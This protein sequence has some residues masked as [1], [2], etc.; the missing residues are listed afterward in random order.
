MLR[1]DFEATKASQV[2]LLSGGG[3]GHEP[4]H[5]GWLG[6]GMLTAA[7]CGGVFASPSVDAVLSG[8]RACAGP[9][10]VLVIVKN[11]TGDR[12]NFGLACEQA[13]AEG[14]RCEMVIVGDD[15]AV[16]ER[17]ED[18]IAGRRG[19]AGTVFVHKCAGA[20]AAAGAPLAQVLAV[21]TAAERSVGSVG[22]ALDVCSL[23]GQPKNDRLTGSEMEMGLGIHGEPGTQK[24]TALPCDEIVD[25]MLSMIC[26]P[27][28][29][30]RWEGGLSKGDSVVLLVN[31]LGSTPVMEQYV[32]ARRAIEHLETDLGVSV[33]RS[34]VGSFMTSLDMAGVSLTLMKLSYF[35]DLCKDA[36]KARPSSS[37]AP[38]WS[39]VFDPLMLLDAPTGA[40]AWPASFAMQRLPAPEHPVPAASGGVL[41]TAG[42]SGPSISPESAEAVKKA[43]MAAVEAVCAAEE[44]LTAWDAAAGDGDCGTTM[45]RGAEQVTADLPGYDFTSPSTLLAQLAD[46]IGTMGGTSGVI[47]DIFFRACGNSYAGAETAADASSLLD[48]IEAGTKAITFYGGATEGMRTLLDAMVPAHRAGVAAA[49]VE[50]SVALAAMAEAA[51]AG[52]DATRTMA[53]VAGR[54]AYVPDQQ[55]QGTPDPG[56]MAVAFALQAAATAASK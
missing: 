16:M 47:L 5:G 9:H 8:I 6:E 55:V 12:L 31:N 44:Q 35:E 40:V 14:I 41:A 51:M 29:A 1:A 15:C 23:P 11:Y 49:T 45:K 22:V 21:A 43:V 3:S 30:C 53:A 54:A 52:A 37:L 26:D 46:S 28:G 36:V 50:V 18:K 48:A 20:A 25:R 2:T 17:D 24:L 56:A 13:K 19:I 7:V 38:G 4:S 34:Y 33:A 32:A 27:A 39:A 10:G 42:A